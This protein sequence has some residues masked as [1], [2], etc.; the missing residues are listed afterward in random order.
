MKSKQQV[1]TEL[2]DLADRV[3][4]ARRAIAMG[5]DISIDGIEREIETV[6]GHILQLP[7]EDALDM[8]DAL[9]SLQSDLEQL[10]ADMDLAGLT[11][12]EADVLV[13]EEDDED[14]S[15][16]ELDEGPSGPSTTIH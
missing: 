11:G 15:A 16:M 8:R 2:K 7:H 13:E 1:I 5:D 10:S 3:A 14:D 6:C 9:H 12:P 4:N